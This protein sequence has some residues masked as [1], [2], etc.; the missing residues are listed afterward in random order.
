[1]TK[2]GCGC[3]GKREFRDELS[4]KIALANIWRKDRPTAREKRVYRCPNKHWIW[5]LTSQEK[6]SR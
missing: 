5:H 6:R 1:M 2:T 3:T 4:A